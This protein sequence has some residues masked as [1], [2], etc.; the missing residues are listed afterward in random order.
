VKYPEILITDSSGKQYK[1]ATRNRYN[2]NSCRYRDFVRDVDERLAERFGH[3]PDVIGWQIDHE[4]SKASFDAETQKQFQAWLKHRYQTIDRLNQAWTTAYNNQTYSA[5]DQIPMVDRTA[6]NSPGLWLDSKRF[7]S[8]SLR[9][10]QKVQID[11]VRKYADSRQKITTNMMGWFDLY[12]HYTVAQDLDIVG[13][14][15]PQVWGSFD[16]AR[17]GVAHDLMRGLKGGNYWVLEST[18]GPRGGENASVMLE[19]GEMR[20]AIWGYIGRGADLVSYWQWRD[21]LNGGE[22]NHGAIV[23]VDGEPDPIYEEYKQLGEEFEKVAPYLKDTHVVSEV[24]ILHAYPSRWAMLRLTT[25]NSPS[26]CNF[27]SSSHTDEY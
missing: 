17:N 10:Y 15:N 12:D 9:S 7:I 18:A 11:A 27:A 6:D 14:D 5:W 13:W 3:N 22:Q 16:P 8:E 21:A 4:Y 24:A 1:G 25:F 20:A 23:D 26:T 19:R 2:W